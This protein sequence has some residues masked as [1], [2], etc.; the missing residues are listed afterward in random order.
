MSRGLQVLLA[1]LRV[2]AGAS[3]LGP[4][5]HKLG[6]LRHPALEQ[7]LASWSAHADNPFIHKYLQLMIPHSAW[8]ARAVAVGEIGIGA[9]LILGLLTPLVSALAFL[10]VLNFHFAS[11]AMTSL[12]YLGGQSG[13]VYLLLFPVLAVGRAGL[14]F[15]VD[16]VLGRSL[17]P[18]SL[19]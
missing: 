13:L 8:L 14:A 3:L 2:A 19:R 18:G 7:Q 4:G 17:R 16:G 1:L 9:L 15:G 10:M 11:G 5:L 12:Q 6:W